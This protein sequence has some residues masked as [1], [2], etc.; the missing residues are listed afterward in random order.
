MASSNSHHFMHGHALQQLN[1]KYVDVS[2]PGYYQP[3]PIQGKAKGV[4]A[5]MWLAS[6]VALASVLAPT[7]AQA[8]DSYRLTGTI[9]LDGQRIAQPDDR[10]QE[11][12]ESYVI[13]QSS[14]YTVRL[15][16][17]I[18]S[19]GN[20]LVDARFL[21]EKQRDESWETLMQPSVQA[22]LGQQ[23]SVALQAPEDSDEVDVEFVFTIT[24]DN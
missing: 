8:A 22:V 21:I 18:Q 5:G 19:A 15:T 23:S 20:N 4:I 16:Y 10:T 9:S 1:Q 13:M 11:G 17:S 2:T 6:I 12:S 7:V 3:Q 24:E 14:D